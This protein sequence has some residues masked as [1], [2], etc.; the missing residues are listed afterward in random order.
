MERVSPDTLMAVEKVLESHIDFAQSA[1][2]LG[3]VKTAA[4]ILNM[5]GQRYEKN[6]INGIAKVDPQLAGEIKNLMFVFEDMIKLDN[7]SIQKV[8]KEVDNKELAMALKACSEPLKEKILSNMSKRAADMISEELSYM[9]PVRLREVESVQQHV[10]DIIRRL[11]EEGE[12]IIST[13]A[14][15]DQMV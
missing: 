3:G 13:G 14:E 5:V 2:K 4:E 12:V 10:I 7:R 8:L 11:E 9:G 15:E 6:I 1:S